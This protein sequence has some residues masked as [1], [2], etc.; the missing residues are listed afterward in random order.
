MVIRREPAE[1]SWT[2]KAGELY[3]KGKWKVYHALIAAFKTAKNTSLNALRKL[4]PHLPDRTQSAVMAIID[5]TD[6]TCDIFIALMLAIIG[7]AVGFVEGI[8][9]LI[10]GILKMAYG[11]LKLTADYLLAVFGSPDAYFKDLE[12]I[13]TAIKNIPA[14]LSKV[15]NEWLEKYKHASAEDQVLMGAE[16]IGQLE[17]VIASFALVPGKA[18]QAAN[19]AGAAERGAAATEGAVDA[20]AAAAEKAPLADAPAV[21]GE[22]AEIENALNNMRAEGEP[23]QL[24]PHE[25]ATQ[26]R[27]ALG[28][29]GSEVQS[30]HGAPQSVMKRVPGYNPRQAL[31]TLMDRTAHT[32]MD[33]FWKQT[34]QAMQKAGRSTATAREVEQIVAESIRRAPALSAGQKSSLI[35]RLS[36]EMFVEFGLRPDDV[37]DLPYAHLAP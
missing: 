5:G 19:A 25:A 34:F 8:V 26:N 2:R 14:G 7:L 37:L 29:S 12:G 20:A 21:A 13:V 16:L 27:Q 9:G 28:Q 36:D 10:T 6:M 18:G 17:A 30:A 3:D 31:T 11:L 4:V 23:V 24:Q 33:R 32:G 22:D 15:V 35:A 1:K